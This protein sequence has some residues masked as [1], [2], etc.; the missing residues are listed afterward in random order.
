MPTPTKSQAILKLGILGGGQLGRM[1][2]HSAQRMGIRTVVLDPDINSPAGLVSEQHIVADYNDEEGWSQLRACNA[3]TTEFE[4]VPATTLEKLAQTTL[5]TPPAHAVAIAQNRIAEK[6]YFTKFKIASV[7]HAILCASSDLQQIPQNIFPALLKTANFGY[8]GKGQILV[9]D[10][11]ELKQAW[12]DLQQVDCVLEKRLELAYECS[13]IIA[14]SK[15][16]DMVFFKPQR[17]VHRNGILAAT[18][19]FDDAVPQDIAHQLI[20]ASKDIADNLAY[21]GVL[22]VEFFVLQ[23]N[24]WVVNEIAPRPHNSGHY[25]IDACE[26][27]QFDL[28]VRT[29]L[30]IPLPQP[31]QHSAAIMLNLLGNMWL[32][33]AENITTPSWQKVQNISGV[34]LHLYGKTQIR[35]QRKMGHI[36][37]TAAD[38]Q[39]VQQKT[40]KVTQLL[41][42]HC[43]KNNK[44]LISNSLV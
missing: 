14:R 41:G 13:V 30:G 20:Q 17:N 3:I 2:A 11:L 4:N 32:D 25:T 9:S 33:S 44:K 34:H 43:E 26:H 12:I 40:A 7:P 28:Q 22:C 21:V 18:Y 6:N 5:V 37:I 24:S 15:T 42:L 31:R 29:S 19:A 23:D 39:T 16:G 10:A 8:D 27:S 36:T 1:L 35:P 38:A